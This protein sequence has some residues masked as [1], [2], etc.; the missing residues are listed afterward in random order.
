M[1]FCFDQFELDLESFRLRR[2]PEVVKM[3]PLVLRLLAVLVRNAERLVTR[4]QLVTEV[5]ESRS[6]PDNVI[7]VSIA[8]LRRTL[9]EQRGARPFIVTVYGH[10]YRFERPVTVR[11][12]RDQEVLPAP[13]ASSAT[14][15]TPFVGRERTLARLRTA[16][17]KLCKGRGRAFMVLGETGI[18]K[19]RLLEQVDHELTR[20]SVRIAWGTCRDGGATTPLQPW[21][22][23]LAAV[24]E[25]APTEEWEAQLGSAARDI[26][27]LLEDGGAESALLDA[28]GTGCASLL[29]TVTRAFTLAARREPWVF[30]LEDLHRADPASLTLL[31]RLLEELPHTR[32]LLL[33]TACTSASE[34]GPEAPVHLSGVIEHAQ[35]EALRLDR[36]SE[37][38]VR[39]YVTELIGA[40]HAH[41]VPLVY[42]ES[43]GCPFMMTERVAQLASELE[44]LR[45]R[46]GR[47][48]AQTRH[49]LCIAA[50]LGR[51][52]AL[53]QLQLVSDCDGGALIA[54][55][56]DAV[57]AGLIVSSLE[58]S[59]GFRFCQELLRTVLYDSLSRAEQRRWH[60]R[61]AQ[62]LEQRAEGGALI[63]PGT[64]AHHFFAAMPETDL[65]KTVRYCLDAANA[66]MSVYAT[67]DV[68]RHAKH[69]LEALALTD[70]PNAPLRIALL[71]R[72]GIYSRSY[73]SV[74]VPAAHEVMRLARALED[75]RSLVMAAMMCMAHP[76]LAPIAGARAAMQDALSMLPP[77]QARLRAV[78]LAMLACAAP[79]GY[80]A[81]QAQKR[82]AESEQLAHTHDCPEL[83]QWV[84][85]SR[86]YAEGGPHPEREGW[87]IPE[88]LERLARAH[89]SRVPL[90]P[91][92]LS[93]YDATRALQLGD[94]RA[95]EAAIESASARA[96]QLNHREMQWHTDRYR[97]LSQVHAG[98]VSEVS[99]PLRALHR[100]AEREGLLGTAPFC[101]FDR[102]VVLAELGDDGSL[103]DDRTRAALTYDAEDPPSLW[104]LKVRALYA[105]G[106]HRE[107][108]ASLEA[109]APSALAAL[110]RDSQYLGT[111]GH[112]ARVALGLGARAYAQALFSLLSPHRALFAGHVAFYCEGSV[113]QLLGLLAAA[114]DRPREAVALLEEGV[115]AAERAGYVLAALD[116]QLALARCLGHEPRQRPRAL[117]L[118]RDVQRTAERLGLARIAQLAAGFLGGAEATESQEAGRGA[119]TSYSG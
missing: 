81:E 105:A 50:V 87:D 41:V 95:V 17:A 21:L 49:T 76:E 67:A 93:R 27:P 8:R 25:S 44:L 16:V 2:G 75:G 11:A 99:R 18:G 3:E 34:R 74:F 97:A 55:L 51:S 7:A 71:L 112:L 119:V 101:A 19:T 72:L 73:A 110:P 108:R 31:A 40:T 15:R 65:M 78:A 48:D 58:S 26:A 38:E 115:E 103:L 117:A 13:T 32:I 52:F 35:C 43:E 83:A 30:V 53:W 106:M 66:A 109:V 23:I 114:L 94:A 33:G 98:K 9:G 62:A 56:D 10:G 6:V 69:A 82:L 116:G 1:I 107:A 20:T 68:Q 100:Q 86:L 24:Y 63:P 14:T 47:L 79:A 104:S 54:R 61:I 92:L 102:L 29:D 59:T 91:L 39:A 37:D 60:L 45:Q 70:S 84:L 46:V 5:W 77:S 118:V 96:R 12:S 22:R 4:E 113:A 85:L 36:L 111:L 42:A 64:L 88:Q 57:A 90:V 89:L 28:S 80:H